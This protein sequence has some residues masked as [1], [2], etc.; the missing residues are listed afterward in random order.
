MAP[1]ELTLPPGAGARGAGLEA[2]PR[3]DVCWISHFSL[4]PTSGVLLATKAAMP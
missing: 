3:F 1:I 2:Y 4:T